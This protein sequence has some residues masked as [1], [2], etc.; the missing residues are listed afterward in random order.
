MASENNYTDKQ[1]GNYRVISKL[2][3]GAFGSVYLG[4][5]AIFIKRPVVAIK[6]LHAYLDSQE[7]RDR[8]LQEAEWLEMLQ[9]QHILPIIDAGFHEGFPYMVTEYAP[10][11]SLRDR[12]RRQSGKPLP[13]QEAI[14]I[15]S[16]IGE[17]LHHAHE[18]HIIHRDLKPENILFNAK[19]VIV[20][21]DFGIATV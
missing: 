8:F 6:L 19:G 7:E 5:H 9:H 14:S 2:A 16:Q 15:L 18:Q 21:A 11:G 20:L 3:S 12:L 10:N 17:A 1:I 13:E 4:K